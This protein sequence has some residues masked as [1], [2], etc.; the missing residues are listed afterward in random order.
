MNK[1][2][3]LFKF[4]SNPWGGGNQF[5]KNLK[6]TFLEFNLYSEKI[7]NS[8]FI[9]FNSHH[10]FVKTIFL[11]Y[12]YPRKIFIHR[13]DGPM[14]YRGD[15]YILNNLIQNINYLVA[16]GTIFQSK[17]SKEN[18]KNI[19]TKFKKIICNAPDNNIFKNLIKKKNDNKKIRIVSTCWSKNINKGHDDY[20]FLDQNLD[21]AKYEVFL[22]G[23][24]NYKFKNINH[25]KPLK[26]DKI[27]D[28]FKSS[29]IFFFPSKIEACSNSLLEAIHSGLAI[30]AANTS[31]NPELIQK[32]GLCYSSQNE[33]IDS[34][35]KVSNNLDNYQNNH[36]LPTLKSVSKDYISLFENINNLATKFD[37]TSKKIN[38]FSCFYFIIKYSLL[39][40]VEKIKRKIIK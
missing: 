23:R 25:I 29:N 22:I 14:N 8:K 31:S 13:I 10:H 19:N 26:S 17:W 21:F 38:L 9:L 27:F 2:N 30:V 4:T 35:N 32:N 6:K 24:T 15:G 36:L 1:I 5:L 34:I 39:M 28:Y 40:F 12:I 16:D 20:L 33:I 3:I 11:K 37:Y 18:N 7:S